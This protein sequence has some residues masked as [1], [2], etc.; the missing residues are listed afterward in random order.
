MA[1]MHLGLAISG[2]AFLYVGW[3]SWS[4]GYTPEVAAVRAL[5]AFMAVNFVA[6]IGQLIVVTQ[7]PK[8]AAEESEA[9][10]EAS[11]DDGSSDDRPALEIVP[12]TAADSEAD[13]GRLAA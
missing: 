5:V 13:Q 11:V 12:P 6:Y 9:E 10:A 1:V 3:A 7:P 4:A 8:P 2:I